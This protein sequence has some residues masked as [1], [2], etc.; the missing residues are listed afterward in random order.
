MAE[1]IRLKVKQEYRA[2]ALY[3]AAGS[4]IDVPAEAGN[5]LMRDA[6]GCF[7]LYIEKGLD[8]P[9]ADKMLRQARVKK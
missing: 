8:R 4:I 9:P 7:E 1:T 2:G 6:P 3:Y 5:W